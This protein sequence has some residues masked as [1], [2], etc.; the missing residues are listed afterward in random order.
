[1]LFSSLENQIRKE[2][3]EIENLQKRNSMSVKH[4]GSKKEHKQ[5]SDKKNLSAFS[6]NTSQ[7]SVK[8]KTNKS[9]KKRSRGRRRV[10]LK[11]H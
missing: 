8:A 3:K 5:S 2:Q 11:R 9:G 10:K 4:R 6:P 7:V 1:M